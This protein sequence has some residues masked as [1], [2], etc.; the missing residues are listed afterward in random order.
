LVFVTLRFI[1]TLE[2]RMIERRKCARA[3]RERASAAS[4]DVTDE[5]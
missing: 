1:D 5:Q 4:K 3:K 2:K